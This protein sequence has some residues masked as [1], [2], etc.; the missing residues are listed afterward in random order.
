M[1]A[2]VL[3]VLEAKDKKA[4]GQMKSKRGRYCK[5]RLKRK[6]VHKNV[7]L[8]TIGFYTASFHTCGSS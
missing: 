6:E 7:K 3:R 4:L 1:K 2:Q 5:Y 8:L